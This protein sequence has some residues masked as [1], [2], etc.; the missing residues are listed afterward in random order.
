M[1]RI[2]W[3][4][5]IYRYDVLNLKSILTAPKENG[6]KHFIIVQDILENPEKAVVLIKQLNNR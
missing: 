6:T 5:D 1:D 3:L 2:V 4:N